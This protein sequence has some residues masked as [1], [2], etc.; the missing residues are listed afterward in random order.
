[1]LNI[2]P[3]KEFISAT[4]CETLDTRI[5]RRDWGGRVKA[6]S[7]LGEPMLTYMQRK[8]QWH[9][10]WC[11]VTIQTGPQRFSAASAGRERAAPFMGWTARRPA[12]TW[13]STLL[14]FSVR[15]LSSPRACLVFLPGCLD[16]AAAMRSVLPLTH[17]I[18][19]SAQGVISGYLTRL[20]SNSLF[21]ITR[22]RKQS[23]VTCVHN[24]TRGREY[25]HQQFYAT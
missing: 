4:S 1:M 16:W 5:F 24:C 6:K 2:S 3:V 9:S 23:S 21:W 14:L 22:K 15:D 17:G 10:S 20:K 7:L 8:F 11:M 18:Y 25:P 19:V 13:A 12:V